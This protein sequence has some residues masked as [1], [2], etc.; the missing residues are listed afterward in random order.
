MHTTDIMH[1][2]C[3]G[4]LQAA[5][6][7]ALLLPSFAQ[8]GVNGF[9]ERN[10][11]RLTFTDGIAFFDAR[12]A[13]GEITTTV[14][15]TAKKLDRDALK[16]CANCRDALPEDNFLSPRGRAINQQKSAVNEG[17]IELSHAGGESTM[18]TI[19]NIMYLADDGVLKGIN[20]SNSTGSL[21]FSSLSETHLGGTI[22]TVPTEPEYFD[23]SDMTC[24][25]S[26][27]LPVGWP[28]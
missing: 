2:Q 5:L 9:C 4:P 12:D 28:K 10:G 16:A 13:D 14:Y 25:V 21:T 20:G 19:I 6:L 26:F 27:D 1:T 24:D 23:D 7:V 8:A 15:L 18:G 3:R 17:W 11:K 22:K